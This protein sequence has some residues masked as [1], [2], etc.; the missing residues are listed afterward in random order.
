MAKDW[1]LLR[2]VSLSGYLQTVDWSRRLL[3]PGKVYPSAAV[4]DI[5]SRLQIDATEWKSTLEKLLGSTKK[6]GTYFGS[7]K[8]LNDVAKQRGCSYLR[9]ITECDVTLASPVSAERSTP[10]HKSGC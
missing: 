10:F 1:R 4:P 9:N 2:G 3:C 8:R 6:I 7:R 5:L